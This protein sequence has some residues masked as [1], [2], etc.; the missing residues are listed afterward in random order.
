VICKCKEG[1]FDAN[2]ELFHHVMKSLSR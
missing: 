1:N 2:K